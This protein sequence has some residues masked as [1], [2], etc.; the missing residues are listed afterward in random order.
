[1]AAR[2]DVEREGG[3]RVGDGRRLFDLDEEAEALALEA[4]ERSEVA[5]G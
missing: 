1:M 2:A 3:A 4:G 5:R